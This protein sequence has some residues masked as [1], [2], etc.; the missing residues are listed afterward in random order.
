M[1][2]TEPKMN[3]PPTPTPEIS[4][5][6]QAM[7]NSLFAALEKNARDKFWFNVP[8][9]SEE[10]NEIIRRTTDK[11]YQIHE[12][13]LKSIERANKRFKKRMH[14][15]YYIQDD[16]WDIIKRFVLDYTILGYKPIVQAKE[17]KV[18]WYIA[19]HHA[20]QIFYNINWKNATNF[21][22]TPKNQK[23]NRQRLIN[24]KATDE[25]LVFQIVQESLTRYYNLS[26]Y[27]AIVKVIQ[28]VKICKKTIKVNVYNLVGD[29]LYK[30]M[31]SPVVGK[32]YSPHVMR[33]NRNAEGE[34]NYKKDYPY[35]YYTATQHDFLFN[36]EDM[37]QVEK[38]YLGVKKEI[39]MTSYD[40]HHDS[41]KDKYMILKPLYKKAFYKDVTDETK[42][43]FDAHYHRSNVP[44]WEIESMTIDEISE[45]INGH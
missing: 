26:F 31:T 7:C 29:T 32:E 4:E 25:Q 8:R 11:L 6:T 24:K 27:H 33:I 1:M 34:L 43:F 45:E 18:G 15:G 38:S 10:K 3:P 30:V 2:N 39:K 21:Q 28:I 22:R 14:D 16:C 13:N 20:K 9:Q 19:S 17:L 36:L 44:A 40:H 23:K 42:D 35:D 5:E 12:L 41:A 37:M